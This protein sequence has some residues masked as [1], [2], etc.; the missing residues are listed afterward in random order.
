M[1]TVTDTEWNR[2]AT[3]FFDRRRE[4]SEQ[5]RADAEKR[6]QMGMAYIWGRQD[7][8]AEHTGDDSGIDST[9]ALAFGYAYGLH[10]IDYFTEQT[11]LL[12]N[13]KDAFERWNRGEDMTIGRD[14][15]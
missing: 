6:Q 14:R 8:I 1:R 5:L 12:R 10:A 13:V 7:A 4:L 3:E 2:A 11:F 9:I 15:A